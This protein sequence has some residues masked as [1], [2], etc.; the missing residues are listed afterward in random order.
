MPTYNY[1]FQDFYDWS[2]STPGQLFEWTSIIS[3]G[4][5][6]GFLVFLVIETFKWTIN[7]FFAK[8]SFLWADWFFGIYNSFRPYGIN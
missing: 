5:F 8:E 3:F 7:T 6:I 1:K 4:T 2:V